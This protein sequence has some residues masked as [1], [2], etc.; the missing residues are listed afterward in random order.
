M[1]QIDLKDFFMHNVTKNDYHYKFYDF[2]KNIN[3]TYNPITDEME[4]TDNYEF[5]IYDS[6]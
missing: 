2:I 1:G 6:E 3:N 5:Y 4:K